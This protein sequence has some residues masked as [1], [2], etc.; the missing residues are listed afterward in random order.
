MITNKLDKK[1]Y[2]FAM[3][4]F[5]PVLIAILTICVV[6][7]NLK[8]KE[9]NTKQQSIEHE[10][11]LLSQMQTIENKY[12]IVERNTEEIV[13]KNYSLGSVS[14][15]DKNGTAIHGFTTENET[16]YHNWYSIQKN[17]NGI[18]DITLKTIDRQE[19][20]N[21][22]TTNGPYIIHDRALTINL[23]PYVSL[24]FASVNGKNEFRNAAYETENSY[25]IK[26]AVKTGV[27]EFEM[28]RIINIEKGSWNTSHTLQ[29]CTY[30]IKLI[31]IVFEDTNYDKA[32]IMEYR[33]IVNGTTYEELDKLYASYE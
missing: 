11:Y 7:P 3:M 12:N 13:L 25:K 26:Y 1:K 31:K 5:L 20:K 14:I 8:N 21:D 24:N 29:F 23:S 9:D 30:E 19:R 6:I 17:D 16:V 27:T 10:K 18:F 22:Y 33:F 15:Y 2:A 32:T 28:T 4:L